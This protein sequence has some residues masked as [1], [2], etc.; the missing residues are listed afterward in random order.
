MTGAPEPDLETILGQI[1]TRGMNRRLVRCV[2]ALDFIASVRPRFLYTS[3]RRGRCNPASVE[4]LYFSETEPTADAEHRRPWLGTLAEHQPKLT[5]RA[6]VRLRQI[7]DLANREVIAALSLSRDDLEGNWRLR[8]AATRLQELGL[9]ISRQHSVT[10]VRFPSAAARRFGAKGWNVA[11]FPEA[12]ESPDRVEILGR[13]GEPL[14]VLGGGD[15][16]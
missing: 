11:I 16:T 3:G 15:R 13:S 1:P 6:R 9:A 5:F 14:E 4:C 7:V 8:A 2:P 10:A 12:I